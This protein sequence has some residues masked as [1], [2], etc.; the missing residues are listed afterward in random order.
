MIQK[1]SIK[2]FQKWIILLLLISTS[3]FVYSQNTLTSL[4]PSNKNLLKGFNL[5]FYHN[6]FIYHSNALS[7]DNQFFRLDLNTGNDSLISTLPFSVGGSLPTIS[8]ASQFPGTVVISNNAYLLNNDNSFRRY[9]VVTNSWITLTS[10]PTTYTVGKRGITSDGANYIY[11]WGGRKSLGTGSS[12]ANN[13]S[14]HSDELWRY[15]INTNTWFLLSTAPARLYCQDAIYNYP[16]LY[17]TGGGKWSDYWGGG[18]NYNIIYQFNLLSNTWSNIYSPF[19]FMD[20][21][22]GLPSYYI[23]D[24]KL[25]T[26]HPTTSSSGTSYLGYYNSVTNLWVQEPTI[27]TTNFELLYPNTTTGAGDRKSVV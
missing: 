20:H 12:A 14:Y 1:I 27:T 9:N 3:A 19:S 25:Y 24:N 2:N 7:T 4:M 13:I 26:L 5:N 8:N 17:F 23:Q 11:V 22:Y 16:Y 6:G 21:T 18:P 10:L 15:S